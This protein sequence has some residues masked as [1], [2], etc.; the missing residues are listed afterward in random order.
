MSFCNLYGMPVMMEISAIDRAN[1]LAIL[2]IG[3][4][5]TACYE[6][7]DFLFKKSHHLGSKYA[8]IT[9]VSTIQHGLLM[10]CSSCPSTG[11]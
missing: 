6:I 1:S 9:T 10:I 7:G 8:D 5:T 4:T 11:R 2:A 3:A